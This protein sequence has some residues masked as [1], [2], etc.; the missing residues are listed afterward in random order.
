VNETPDHG[1]SD[2]RRTPRFRRVPL[3][4]IIP[5]MVTLLA[6]CSGLTAVRMAFEGRWEFAVGAILVAAV[7]DGLDGRVARMMKGTSRFGAELDSLSDF[8]NFGVTPALMLY[9]WILKDAGN[10]GWIAALIFAISAALRLARFNVALDDPNKPAWASRFFTG[11]PAPAGALTVLLPLYLDFLGLFPHWFADDAF[12]AAYTIGVAFLL[13]SR[14]PTYSGKTLGT[15]VRRD[16][17]LPLFLVAV[18]IVAMTVSYPFRML[19]GGAVLYLLTIP[20][21]WR[22]HRKLVLA[23]TT[24]GFED[25]GDE[26]D[27]DL[28][29]IADRDK[30]HGG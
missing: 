17:V 18:L 27:I 30:D 15:R 14:L 24:L 16:F 8:V 7:L 6:L 29:N 9:L 2:A 26:C 5:N 20:F 19:A 25:D 12:V 1:S 13:I 10:M 11:V 21:S 3:R 4:L 28:D 22:A 23:D